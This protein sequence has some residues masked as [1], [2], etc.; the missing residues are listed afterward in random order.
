MK[1]LQLYALVTCCDF[2]LKKKAQCLVLGKEGSTEI[3]FVLCLT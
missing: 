3:L 2:H 1:T